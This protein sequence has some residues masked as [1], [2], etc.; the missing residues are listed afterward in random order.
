MESSV[1]DFIEKVVYINLA[2]RTDRREHMENFIKP[3]GDKVIRFEAI[4][5][6][7]GSIGCSKSHVSVIEMAI[8]KNWKNILVLEDD[9]EWNINK[10]ALEEFNTLSKNN[11]DVLL[12]GG[13]YTKFDKN[14][15][16]LSYGC[17]THAYIV[18]NHYFST[19]LQNFRESVVLYNEFGS[20]EFHIDQHWNLLM[21]NDKWFI[22]IPSLVYQHDGYSDVRMAYREGI[23]RFEYLSL[24][25]SGSLIEENL[26]VLAVYSNPCEWARRLELTLQFIEQMNNEKNVILYVVELAYG[27]Q[28]HKVTNKEN[29]RHLQLQCDTPMWHKENL[30]NIGVKKLLPQNWKAFAWI[31][32]DIKF[33]DPDWAKDALSILNGDKHIIQ[34]F[35]SIDRLDKEGNVSSSESVVINPGFA[36]ACTRQTYEKIGKLHDFSIV[37]GGDTI[38]CDVIKNKNIELGFNSKSVTYHLKRYEGLKYGNLYGTIIHYYHGTRMTRSYYNRL[39]ITKYFNFIPEN[40]LCYNEDGLLVPTKSFPEGMANE[41]M[42]YFRSRKED[43]GLTWEET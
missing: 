2:K 11:F 26:H 40:H 38:M 7:V 41:I 39:L 32:A 29:P 37:G 10:K 27:N 17:S 8:E 3:F 16:K 6:H 1:F 21:P 25:P 43:D 36:W 22:T 4:E 33:E 35:S 20:E 18:N 12:L 9:A 13:T 30:I 14:T 28:K 19:I 42:V 5:H 23:E 31:D 34:L 24:K 15:H